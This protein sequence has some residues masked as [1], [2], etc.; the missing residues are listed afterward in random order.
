M[1]IINFGVLCCPEISGENMENMYILKLIDGMNIVD[2]LKKFVETQN[3]EY[4]VLIS[5]SGSIKDF[6]LVSTEPR[7]GMSR[8]LFRNNYEINSVSGKVTL[9]KNKVEL[10]IRV[11]VS[12]T[13][14]TSQ[15][16]QLIKGTV[17][18]FLEL[19][20]RKVNTKNI[21]GA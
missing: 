14:F 17:A 5:A 20:I 21:I 11:S 15:T 18:G 6:E 3:I 16:G 8:N 13:G 12:D 7:G 1:K 10:N 9:V 2:E 4:G 19:G